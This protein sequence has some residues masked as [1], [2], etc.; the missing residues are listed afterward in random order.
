MGQRHQ[1]YLR[2]PS[3][4]YQEGNQNN[5]PEI[6]VGLHHQWL[7][8]KTAIQLLGNAL[9]YAEKT[10]EYH[11]WR[12]SLYKEDAVQCLAAIYSL[13]QND[14]YFH[15]VHTD[16]DA[17][18]EDP[19]LG[20]NND[21]ITVIDLTGPIPS[22][23]FVSLGGI[24]CSEVRRNKIKSLSPMPAMQYLDAYYPN[25]DFP[26]H[27]DDRVTSEDRINLKMECLALLDRVSK[28]PVISKKRLKEIFPKMYAQN[29]VAS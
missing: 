11:P 14:G 9:N 10:G 21:G 17:E 7:Y 13:D 24:E 18:C 25:F 2:L 19:R 8:G 23:C 27:W 26:S 20:D 28:F 5:R 29:E 3:T 1:V 16:L 6:T 4:H 22:Y 12:K 15:R